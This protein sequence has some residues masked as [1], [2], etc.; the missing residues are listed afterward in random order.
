MLDAE[1]LGELLP[2]QTGEFYEPLQPLAE[3]LREELRV[4]AFSLF[5]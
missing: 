3:V 1:A 2:R 5:A 4:R